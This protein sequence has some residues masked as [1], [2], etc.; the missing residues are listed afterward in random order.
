MQSRRLPINY[1]SLSVQFCSLLIMIRT[2]LPMLN[3]IVI[4]Y[5]VSHDHGSHESHGVT[6]TVLHNIK[7]QQ[8]KCLVIEKVVSV[9]VK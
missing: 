6:L 8:Y 9:I 2:H 5:N 7:Y 4:I 1:I 3:V